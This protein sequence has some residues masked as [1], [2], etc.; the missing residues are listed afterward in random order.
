MVK[1]KPW[2]VIVLI[3]VVVAS[4]GAAVYYAHEASIV[5]T[6]SLCR[7][8]N[9][10]SSHVYNPARLQTVRDCITVSG[11]VNNVIAED[12]GDYHIWFHVDSQYASLP[13][14]ANNDYRQGDL[15]AEIICATTITQQDAVLACE[16]YTNQILPIPNSNQNITVTGP[17]VLDNVHGW[18]EVHPV[19]SLSS[20]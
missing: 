8:P 12:D 11:I 4:V 14:S 6:P 17:Y 5:G 18:M 3:L 20:S 9:N 10:I 19:Y 1:M 16:N 13:N 15:L 7:D 2:P